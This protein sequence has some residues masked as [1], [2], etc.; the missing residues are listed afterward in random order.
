MAS[1]AGVSSVNL[2]S[3]V[4]GLLASLVVGVVLERWRRRRSERK[5]RVAGFERTIGEIAVEHERVRRRETP[6]VDLKPLADLLP[7]VKVVRARLPESVKH[8]AVQLDY[9]LFAYLAESE[10]AQGEGKVAR[11]ERLERRKDADRELA[12]AITATYTAL[13]KYKTRGR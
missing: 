6:G 1:V 10:P 11:R 8:A 9:S 7:R 5:E 2:W 13:E 3:V 4:F 12:D